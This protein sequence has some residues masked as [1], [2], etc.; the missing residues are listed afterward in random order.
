MAHRDGHKGSSKVIFHRSR[1]RGGLQRG[2]IETR[3]KFCSGCDSEPGQVCLAVEAFAYV[4][5]F[6]ADFPLASQLVTFTS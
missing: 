5:Y 2:E 6:P 3:C 1:S 4:G